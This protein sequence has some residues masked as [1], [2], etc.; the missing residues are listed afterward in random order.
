METV[1]AINQ[2]IKD[3]TR[4]AV[5]KAI[6][7]VLD[8][9]EANREDVEAN[10]KIQPVIIDFNKPPD[11]RYSIPIDYNELGPI[12]IHL[13][14]IPQTE[15]IAVRRDTNSELYE[16]KQNMV[17]CSKCRMQLNT[18][19]SIGSYTSPAVIYSKHARSKIHEYRASILILN[20]DIDEFNL[21][22]TALLSIRNDKKT[23]KREQSIKNEN[24]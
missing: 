14:D 16:V 20:P 13:R 2:F 22:K 12:Q 17:I 10:V 15:H 7:E 1:N 9:A 3:A 19:N 23:I 6:N 4:K 21:K 11:E 18:I 8:F 24:N 5:S